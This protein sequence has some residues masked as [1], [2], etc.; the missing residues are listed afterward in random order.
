M[1]I[2]YYFFAI[3]VI[4]TIIYLF[5][6]CKKGKKNNRCNNTYYNNHSFINCNDN[7]NILPYD[8]YNYYE[9]ITKNRNHNNNFNYNINNYNN[10]N[11]NII[12]NNPSDFSNYYNISNIFNDN[13]KSNIIE[14]NHN[15][16]YINNN[17]NDS[18]YR[19]QN[20]NI[21]NANI[22]F[23]NYDNQA[24]NSYNKQ[25][26]IALSKEIMPKSNIMPKVINNIVEEK[27]NQ[28]E[29][30][31]NKK[32]K[33][34]N[35]GSQ[36]TM[37]NLND[38]KFDNKKQSIFNDIMDIEEN[39]NNI[40]ESHNINEDFSQE[41]GYIALNINEEPKIGLDNIGAT[42]YMNA[43]LQCLSHTILL[44]N[45]FLSP[46]HQEFIS[47]PEKIFSKSFLEVI[48]KLWIKEYNN[49]KKSYSP[50]DFK[51]IIS[52]MNPL[53]KGVAANDSKDLVNFILQQLHSELNSIK[54]NNK[55]KNYNNIDQKDEKFMFDNFLD[56][57]KNNHC[58]IIS[59]IFFGVIETITECISCKQRNQ[60][61]GNYNPSF[62]YNFQI[63]NF[64]IFPLEEIRKLKSQMNNYYCNEVD[65]Y[66]CFEY[67]ERPE[68]M[69]GDNAMWCKYCKQNAPAYYKTRIYFP[70]RYLILILNRGKGNIFNVK[71]NFKEFIDI[72]KYVHINNNNG[73]YSYQ[74]YAIV[75]HLGP[76]SMSG[77]FI[78][79]CKSSIDNQWYKYNDSQVN[80]IGNFFNDIHE[81]GCPY[82]LF[83]EAKGF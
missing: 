62:L 23:Y 61:L 65:I 81:F 28:N 24:T 42:C 59:G 27:Y 13:N 60:M 25:K 64:I 41:I 1:E 70:P 53:F 76:S 49:N 58:S 47:S 31:I 43:T 82:I 63:I 44:A 74:L 32:R 40:E 22:N 35:K 8:N 38:K 33:R 6:L 20:N 7:N 12:N 18:Q 73:N 75:T 46:K 57:F 29:Q 4:I 68:L 77:H 10:N 15:I 5:F 21:N 45:Y 36:K 39:R 78:A 54:N 79:F 11:N 80:L 51:N 52:E 71:L 72:K 55:I 16:R 30:V 56:D 17:N 83:Y 34:K 2:E 14:T 50:Y 37:V 67:Y 48:K 9:N 69:Q 3:I 66:D 19:K 26:G